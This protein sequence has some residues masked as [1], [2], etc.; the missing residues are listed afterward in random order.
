MWMM[1]RR[2]VDWE[3]EQHENLLDETME[4]AENGEHELYATI[5]RESEVDET[6]ESKEGD[7]ENP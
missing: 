4:R 7:L 2:R 1:Q 3:D 6:S 5:I